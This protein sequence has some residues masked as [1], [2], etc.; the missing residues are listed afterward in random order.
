M[1]HG[2][3]IARVA[4]VLAVLGLLL[5]RIAL[6]TDTQ[7]TACAPT[8]TTCGWIRTLTDSAL[9]YWPMP[10]HM[11]VDPAGNVYIAGETYPDKTRYIHTE[12]LL[13]KYDRAGNRLWLRR[14]RA[15]GADGFNVAYG[16]AVDAKGNICLGG[17]TDGSYTD[18]K[19][20]A[21]R[22]GFAARYDSDG[23]QLW[24]ADRPLEVFTMAQDSRGNCY[25]VSSNEVA[26]Y[27]PRGT[28]LWNHRRKKIIDAAVE[29]DGTLHIIGPHSNH[30]HFTLTTLNR[31]GKT[32]RTLALELAAGLGWK[33]YD[34]ARLVLKAGGGNVYLHAHL[35][36]EER[37]GKPR[38]EIYLAKIANGQLAWARRH[39]SEG[40]RWDA[41]D[42]TLDLQGNAY[43]SGMSQSLAQ[44][45]VR[46][47][48]VMKYGVEGELRW[49]RS[50]RSNHN[51]GAGSISIDG[52]GNVYTAGGTSG[53]LDGQPVTVGRS[54]TP[55]IARNRPQE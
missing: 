26:K 44:D 47:G 28:L 1:N 32:V 5:P 55:F 24:A 11:A 51:N 34:F 17:I 6:A 20:P 37:Q 31:D 30:S 21:Q 18:P 2:R 45:G 12:V 7:A 40:K 35:Y 13:A 39:G 29:S 43:L 54:S 33:R 52:H 8:D 41:F 14:F 9:G 23:R 3:P 4:G 38:I 22:K 48:F 10:R 36:G 15:P 49:V 16:I 46:N 27:D 19:A 50:F 42:L 53:E 25:A